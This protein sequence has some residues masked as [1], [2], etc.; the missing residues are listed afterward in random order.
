MAE[1]DIRSILAQALVEAL[2][3]VTFFS[4]DLPP[5]GIAEV[6]IHHRVGQ[7]LKMRKSLPAGAPEIG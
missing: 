2:N 1:D 6:L 7:L 4:P 5:A 3:P